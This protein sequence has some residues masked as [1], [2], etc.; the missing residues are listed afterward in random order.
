L[1]GKRKEEEKEIGAW[2]YMKRTMGDVEDG[3][4]VMQRIKWSE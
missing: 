2:I 4:S 3:G 1:H